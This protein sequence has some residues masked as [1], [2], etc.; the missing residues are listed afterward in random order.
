VG[1]LSNG[2][3]VVAV[4][5]DVTNQGQLFVRQPDAT[6]SP[7][8]G[9]PAEGEIFG[10]ITSLAVMSND[11]IVVG[12]D[13]TTNGQIF[14]R[15][16]VTLLAAT[17][18]P[19]GGELFG[20]VFDV[21]V[22]SD[23][24]IVVGVNNTT[25]GQVFVRDPI[26][27]ALAAGTEPGGTILGPVT[28]VAV[29]S[30]D[31]IAVGT[32]NRT[33]GGNPNEGQVLLREST[34]I[35]GPVPGT[36]GGGTLLGPVLSVAIQSDDDIA[37][38]TTNSLLL[39]EGSGMLGPVTGTPGAGVNVGFPVTALAIQ[40]DDEIAVGT[41][42]TA[43]GGDNLTG[44][45]FLRKGGDNESLDPATGSPPGGEVFS[46]PITGLAIYPMLIF[47]PLEGDFNE[48]NMVDLTDLNLVLFNWDVP[49]NSLPSDWTTM[50]PIDNVGLEELNKVLFNW[51][52]VAG[53]INTVPEPSGATL[54][55]LALIVAGHARFPVRQHGCRAIGSKN[56][57]EP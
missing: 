46:H 52:A 25:N 56:S 34:G 11:N 1:V 19:P 18:T 30:L 28:S 44:Q 47:S 3:I 14:V 22:L 21:D 48:D 38:G 36:P 23:D 27:L 8:P 32:D 13:N 7:A 37:V 6:L 33:L 10:P 41:T 57:A 17:G 55:A 49:A 9:S 39:R 53:K 29:N 16:P 26:T 54:L 24:S 31:Q 5:N 15:D 42:V 35:L 40:S 4:N 12:V 50:L 43:G 45:F 20:P 51:G 2:N